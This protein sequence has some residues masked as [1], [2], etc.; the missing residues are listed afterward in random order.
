MEKIR[1]EIHVIMNQWKDQNV[2]RPNKLFLIGCSTSEIA[3]KRIGTSGSTE[4]AQVIYDEL[5][6]FKR[7]T[8]VN[9]AF[10]CCEHLNRAIVIERDVLDRFGLEEVNAVPHPEAGGAM[11]SYAYR[12]MDEPVLVESIKAEYGMDL[13]D[14]FIGM[15][16]KPV[17][18]PLRLKQKSLGHAHVTFAITRPKLIGGE[19]A[20]YQI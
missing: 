3:G 15:H 7:D 10:Q 12:Q 18:V 1:D 13:G 20:K 6:A 19:R 2:V 9:L 17:V 14:T 16:L 4:L 11:A 8:G 5:N